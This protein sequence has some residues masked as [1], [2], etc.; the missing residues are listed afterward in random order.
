SRLGNIDKMNSELSKNNYFRPIGIKLEPIKIASLIEGS[1]ISLFCVPGFKLAVPRT[2]FLFARPFT[3]APIFPELIY[4]FGLQKML[5][6]LSR[7]H[8]TASFLKVAGYPDIVPVYALHRY[9][10]HWPGVTYKLF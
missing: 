10:I 1:K 3:G 4:I 7:N 6:V 2:A 8:L 5:N 9:Y